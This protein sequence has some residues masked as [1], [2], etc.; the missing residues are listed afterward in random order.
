MITKSDKKMIKTVCG[1][2]EPLT[3]YLKQ[4]MN[5]K[6]SATVLIYED[7]LEI[8]AQGMDSCLKGASIF[9]TKSFS[10]DKYTK[11]F[12]DYVTEKHPDCIPFFLGFKTG[13]EEKIK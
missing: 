5:A 10:D 8:K 3:P 11:Q 6:D 1:C 7:S 13:T 2:I 12:I 4:M 9:E